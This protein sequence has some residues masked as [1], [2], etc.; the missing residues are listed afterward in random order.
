MIESGYQKVFPT[1]E[2]K[3]A[4]EHRQANEHA[5]KGYQ[6]LC[7]RFP[8]FA[9]DGSEQ[10]STRY[11]QIDESTAVEPVRA[12]TVQ[13]LIAPT[14]GGPVSAVTSPRIGHSSDGTHKIANK[15]F[16]KSLKP[17]SEQLKSLGLKP[18]PNP[19]TFSVSSPL[20]G[21][22][23]VTGTIYLWPRNAKIVVSDV[24]GTIT[25]SDVWGQLMPIVGK[26]W[27]HPG[28]AELFSN[29]RKSDYKILYLTARAIGQADSTRDYLFGLTQNDKNK[30][31]DGPLILSPDRLFPSFKREVIDRKPYVFKIAALR[32]IRGLF[33]EFYNPFYAAFGNR[34]TDHR[35]YVHVG[36]PEARIFI[37]DPTGHVHHVNRTYAKTYES[38]SEIAADMF[39]SLG[40]SIETHPVDDE[41]GRQLERE[42][43]LR[44]RKRL[45]RLASYERRPP[46]GFF[47]ATAL[48]QSARDAPT[49]IKW[50]RW[51]NPVEPDAGIRTVEEAE[52][53]R[54]RA[55][56]MRR[57]QGSFVASPKHVD[58]EMMN[59][60]WI[61]AVESL[62]EGSEN[63]LPLFLGGRMAAPI[64]IQN[65]SKPKC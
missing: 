65:A 40:P 43:L 16:K 51:R 17:S 21:T 19:I 60:P 28:V 22:Q 48:S 61:P 14:D 57:Q 31:P 33:P 54:R 11:G 13:D 58:K 15:K 35:A 18:G 30:L 5:L 45:R 55:W 32:D 64:R 27:S 37:I 36:I 46:E 50:E 44:D 10:L 49:Q 53:P 38:M 62:P 25:R 6:C 1:V 9:L 52:V 39:P 7:A 41:V 42:A 34:D 56:A 2:K 47:L 24:D 29:I 63:G 4:W 12:S 3:I 20:Q 8:C 26:D 23:T 59:L